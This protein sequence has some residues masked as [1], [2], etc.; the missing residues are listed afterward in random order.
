MENMASLKGRGSRSEQYWKFEKMSEPMEKIRVLL[1]GDSGV[2]KSS[3]MNWICHDEGL[4]HT[5]ATVGCKC[6]VKVSN[7]YQLS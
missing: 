6:D 1:L 2:G 7:T 3:L 4:K 5:Y